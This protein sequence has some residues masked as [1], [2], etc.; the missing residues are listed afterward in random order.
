[1]RICTGFIKPRLYFG[2]S[3]KFPS[4]PRATIWGEP[5][6]KGS[7]QSVRHLGGLPA[8]YLAAI[9]ADYPYLSDDDVRFAG[10]FS[11]ASRPLS[12]FHAR[13]QSRGYENI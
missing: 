1:M 13:A 5:V 7:R 4:P 10:M 8:S 11:R 12:D 2:N 6:F 3:V 9:R